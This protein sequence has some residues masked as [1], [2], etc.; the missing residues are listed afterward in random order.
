MHL[1]REQI[2]DKEQTQ[3]YDQGPPAY[4][5]LCIRIWYKAP[6]ELKNT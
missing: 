2:Q 5:E 3:H 1:Q 4:K 6:V